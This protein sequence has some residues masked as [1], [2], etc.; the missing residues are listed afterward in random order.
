MKMYEF[1]LTFTEFTAPKVPTTSISALL[2]I[3]A[4]RQPGGKPSSEQMMLNIHVS[5]GLN[6]SLGLKELE[7]G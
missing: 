4:R 5:L 3:M 7:N 6:V 1:R 2:Q